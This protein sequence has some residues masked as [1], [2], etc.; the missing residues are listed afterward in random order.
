MWPLLAQ[1]TLDGMHPLRRRVLEQAVVNDGQ[2]S[3]ATFAAR[4]DLPHTSVRRHLEDLAARGVLRK[5]HFTDPEAWV[6]S[7]RTR[8]NWVTFIGSNG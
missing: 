4:L 6:A 3:T 7:E 8:A 1:I 2:M 5:V